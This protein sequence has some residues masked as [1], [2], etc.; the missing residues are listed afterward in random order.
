MASGNRVSLTANERMDVVKDLETSSVRDVAKKY[1]VHHST[2]RRIH[3]NA[4]K[5]VDFGNKGKLEKQR[6]STR[7]PLCEELEQRPV[8]EGNGERPV[9][10]GNGE[11][12]ADE[13]IELSR[14]VRKKLE[15]AFQCLESCNNH[16]PRSVLYLLEGVKLRILG[17]STEHRRKTPKKIEIKS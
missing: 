15:D 5:I 9:V 16:F 7:K 8:D 2:I 4:T 12:P 13:G 6:K 17:D 14:D 3:Q 1:K 11:R 10:E